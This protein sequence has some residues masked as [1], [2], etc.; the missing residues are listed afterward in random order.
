MT[1]K[2]QSNK[3]PLSEEAATIKR[4][5]TSIKIN[6]LLWKE[7]KIAAIR[8]DMDVSELMEDALQEYLG[9][10]IADLVQQQER[11]KEEKK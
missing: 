8:D 7:A 5:A 6:P 2:G 11:R 4:E 10:S 9:I 3:H 1:P